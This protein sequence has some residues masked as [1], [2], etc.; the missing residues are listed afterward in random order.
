MRL[1]AG[2]ERE[3]KAREGVLFSCGL[4]GVEIESEDDA[5]RK[6]YRSSQLQARVR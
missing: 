2:V 1:L 5:G 6:S 4:S 3:F